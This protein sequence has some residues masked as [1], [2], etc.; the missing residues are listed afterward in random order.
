MLSSIRLIPIA[1]LVALG[2]ACHDSPTETALNRDIAALRA[3]VAPYRDFNAAAAA[4]YTTQLTDCMVMPPLGGMGFHFGKAAL[5]DGT[6]NVAAPE[7]LLYQPLADGS[8]QFVG[9]EFII[10]YTIHSRSAAPPV[11]FGHQLKQNDTF[12]LWAL[13]AWVGIDNPSGLFADWN[14]NV[15]CPA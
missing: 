13:H 5:I 2:S 12:Q 4:G 1:L 14:P 15:S 3:A 10:P 6:L 7:V 9:V 11:L 8:K